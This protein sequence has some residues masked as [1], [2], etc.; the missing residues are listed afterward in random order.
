MNQDRMQA[1]NNNLPVINW[2]FPEA[3][4]FGRVIPKEKLYQQAGANAA[5]KQRVVQQVGQIK[6][7]YKLAE[8]TTNLAKTNA[9]DEI[10]IIQITLKS[11]ILEESILAAID[12]AIPHP[13]LFILKRQLSN[14]TD[15][16]CLVA[17]HK[18]KSNTIA[19]K[20]AWQQS[21]YLK[22]AWFNP[23]RVNNKPLP[24]ATNLQSLYEQLIEA[25]I[26]NSPERAINNPDET[27]S[28]VSDQKASY[29]IEAKKE[30]N[31]TN[32]PKPSIKL[33]VEEKLQAL[34]EI[35]L[36]E[37]KLQTTKAKRDRE[38]Q[39]NRRREL[40]DDY[41]TLKQQL[42]ALQAKI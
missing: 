33:T 30:Q 37:K 14:E 39:F 11:N 35:E 1:G 31:R 24:A 8:N 28:K 18:V 36:L 22:S 27:P 9:V 3:A 12:K 16:I 19:G 32:L 4:R 34:A 15:E 17:A 6:W 38:K 40:N 29:S 42:A 25:L 7:V 21:Q 2:R 26:P 5:L 10:E 41:K 13:T 20:E 23:E